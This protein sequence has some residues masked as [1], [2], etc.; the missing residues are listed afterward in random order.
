MD[1]ILS[2]I[3]G[4]FPCVDDVKVQGSSEE[5]HDIHLL[6]TVERAQQAGLKFNPDKCN[7][8]KRETEYSG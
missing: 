8:K 6:E 5:H 7:I 4:T 3:P 2:G 1:A